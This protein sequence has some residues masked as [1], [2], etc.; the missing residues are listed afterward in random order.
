[1]GPRAAARARLALP[2]LPLSLTP[3]YFVEAESAPR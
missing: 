2:L 1:M 3:F